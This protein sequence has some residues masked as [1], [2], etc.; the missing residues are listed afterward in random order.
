M[1]L[2]FLGA[3]LVNAVPRWYQASSTGSSRRRPAG[4]TGA[5]RR[6]SVRVRSDG[7]WRPRRRRPADWRDLAASSQQLETALGQQ[8]LA[9]GVTPAGRDSPP[10]GA[11]WSA[12]RSR[13]P[14]PAIIRAASHRCS[15]ASIA[16]TFAA[17]PP[18][19]PVRSR[20]FPT[21]AHT[22][23]P[24]PSHIR[25]G[26]SP[27]DRRAGCRD[28]RRTTE[29]AVPAAGSRR[30][31]R[32]CAHRPAGLAGPARRLVHRPGRSAAR[33]RGQA[34]YGIGPWTSGPAR[35]GCRRGELDADLQRKQRRLAIWIRVLLGLLV[36]V[37]G[38]DVVLGVKSV[39]EPGTAVGVGVGAVIVWFV[40][41]PRHS[42]SSSATCSRCCTD[43]ARPPPMPRRTSATWRSPSGICG[44]RRRPMV[45]SSSGHAS[46]P[47]CWPNPSATL[48]PTCVRR[49]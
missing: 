45:S 21:S 31:D 7:E 8:Q 34:A 14:M 36:V 40:G 29:P 24:P 41:Q 6:Q 35:R 23:S 46:S 9:T 38:V 1:F 11:T 2:S 48:T 33:R 27:A 16:R 17:R 47:S 12:R 20:R 5:V 4:P 30:G 18:S 26:G 3:T 19:R 44:A 42:P 37:V 15:A 43:A 49:W 39:I 10:C 22:G 25:A 13:W 28:H 32:S